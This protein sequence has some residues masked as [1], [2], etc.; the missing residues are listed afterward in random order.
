MVNY[1]VN[2][3]SV[4]GILLMLFGLLLVPLGLLFRQPFRVANL[5]QNIILALVY[6]LC[7]FIL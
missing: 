2:I 4:L 1:G 3:A 6:V 5:A 7:G